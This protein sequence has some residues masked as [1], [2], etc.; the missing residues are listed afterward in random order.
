MIG[1]VVGLDGEK[2]SVAPGFEIRPLADHGLEEP[3]ALTDEKPPAGGACG[4]EDLPAP[5]KIGQE[6]LRADDVLARGQRRQD[7]AGVELV[8]RVDADG[9]DR[10]VGEHRVVFRG[11][12]VDA[13]LAASFGPQLT[14]E[15]ADRGDL[16][17]RAGKGGG[18]DAAALAETENPQTER[19]RHWRDLQSGGYHRRTRRDMERRAGHLCFFDEGGRA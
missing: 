1:V 19:V 14:V 11:E 17:Q 12:A 3:A 9:V 8:G 15:I 10:R 4:V 18:D 13:E 6:R 16:P 5:V 2:V 7:V